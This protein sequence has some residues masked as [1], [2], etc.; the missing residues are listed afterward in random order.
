MRKV[1]EAEGY[2]V[3]TREVDFRPFHNF[4]RWLSAGERRVIIPFART[5][6]GLIPARAVRLRRDV[7]QLLRAIKA[8]ALLHRQHRR[9]DD[10]GAILATI[11]EDYA[12][13]LPLLGDLLATTAEVK[14]RA[15]IADTIEAV[16]DKQPTNKKFGATAREVANAL[17]IDRTAAW[18]RLR[19]AEDSGFV[20][21]V[22][23]RRGHPGQ[24]RTT[25]ESLPDADMLPTAEQLRHAIRSSRRPPRNGAQQRNTGT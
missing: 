11:D 13:V 22:E 21:N 14:V 23:E 20:V 5:L 4:Q 1:A 24:Y 10:D 16:K 9:R 25:D 6:V 18:R 19:Q 3:T 7:G 2:N 12:A 8:H 15:A 17:K